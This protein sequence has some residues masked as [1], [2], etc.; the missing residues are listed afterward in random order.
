MKVFTAVGFY[1]SLLLLAAISIGM[2]SFILHHKTPHTPKSLR[3]SDDLCHTYAVQHG[4]VCVHPSLFNTG[5]H[6][7]SC[8]FDITLDLAYLPSPKLLACA[9]HLKRGE[10]R[11]L[12]ER[13]RGNDC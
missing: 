4:S 2:Y 9:K 11:D 8:T 5:L 6:P 1:I 13:P 7:E 12:V 10:K 3:L